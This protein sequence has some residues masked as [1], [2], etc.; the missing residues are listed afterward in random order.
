MV[1]IIEILEKW[2]LQGGYKCMKEPIRHYDGKS[3]GKHVQIVEEN[4]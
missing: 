3:Q 2:R 4:V 1:K